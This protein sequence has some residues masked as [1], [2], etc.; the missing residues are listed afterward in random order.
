MTDFN[1]QPFIDYLNAVDDQLEARFGKTSDQRDLERIAQAQEAGDP[2]KACAEELNRLF[3]IRALN[4]ALR[5]R[6]GLPFF[7][8]SRDRIL[9]TQGIA[10][11]PP[12]DQI[13]IVARVRAFEDFQEDND[14][15]GEHDF[16]SFAHGGETIFWKIDYYDADLE[17][18]SED[19]ADPAATARVLTILLAE[20]W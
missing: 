15:H 6:A 9:I 20:E 5:A 1:A 12:L 11:L 3:T 18:G 16:G 8:R 14:P 13:G 7:G 4:D 17:Q 2:P 10:A 19:P